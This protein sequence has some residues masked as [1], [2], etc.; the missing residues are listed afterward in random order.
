MKFF[1]QQSALTFSILL[2]L[3]S[4]PA[5]FGTL[6]ELGP[7]ARSLSGAYRAIASDNDALYY[8]PAGIA[9]APK[10]NLAVDYLF[11]ITHPHHTVGASVVDSKTGVL[12]AGLAYHLGI[13]PADQSTQLS[14]QA[15]LAL[16]IAPHNVLSLGAELKYFW[17]PST[18]TRGA[19]SYLTGDFGVLAS[20]PAGLSLS[21]V[22]YNLIPVEYAELPMALGAGAALNLG[23]ALIGP[24]GAYSGLT[25]AFDWVLKD[26]LKQ[27]KLRHSLHGGA[28][29][30]LF[31]MWAL[32]TGYQLI[33]ADD[34]HSMSVGTGLVSSVVGL[35]LLFD[36]GIAR[37]DKKTFGA[38]INIYL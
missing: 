26:L 28:E 27:E 37:S 15:L 33:L 3:C 8:N 6:E 23:G 5:S 34:A 11:D 19:A 25:L 12:T 38:A 24:S 14:H 29:L 4:S 36:F 18:G 1:G 20:L 32:R 9:K 30:L 13:I 17:L 10:Y 31:E 7:R 2:Y 21:A 35:D 16:A 22:G